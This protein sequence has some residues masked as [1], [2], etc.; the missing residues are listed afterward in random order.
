[1]LL[2]KATIYLTVIICYSQISYLYV[3]VILTL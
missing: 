3:C 1:M 2:G